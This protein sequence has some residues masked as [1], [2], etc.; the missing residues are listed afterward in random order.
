MV[1]RGGEIVTLH[2]AKEEVLLPVSA[3]P[4]TFNGE[5][6]YNI[7]NALGAVA[8]AQALGIPT[9][10]IISALKSFTAA[11]NPGRG[12]TWT[13]AGVTLFLDFAHN[14]EGVEAA[15]R[16]ASSL[17]KQGQLLVLT[18]SAGDR[19]DAELEAIVDRI[20]HAQPSLVVVRELANYLRGRAPGEVPRIIRRALEARGNQILLGSSEVECLELAL[21][22]AHPG[23]VVALLVHVE[24]E[25]VR[26]FLEAGGWR[27]S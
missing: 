7:E 11:D 8:A 12:E 6:R 13:R 17:R 21:K 3:V 24:R 18:G 5:A 10:A 9:P 2:G 4:I 25:A 26:A 20:H 27:R 19:T 1:T 22:H 16:V 15:L 23:D 14:P